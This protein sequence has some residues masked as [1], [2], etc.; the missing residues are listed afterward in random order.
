[1]PPKKDKSAQG[2]TIK[3]PAAD[4]CDDETITTTSLPKKRGRAKWK[5]STIRT[6]AAVDPAAHER[7]D[8]WEQELEH[9]LDNAED[10]PL[11]VNGLG[12]C[13]SPECPSGV[14]AANAVE[15]IRLMEEAAAAEQA[16]AEPYSPHAYWRG[17]VADSRRHDDPARFFDG[18]LLPAIACFCLRTLSVADRNFFDDHKNYMPREFT[19][20]GG[21]SGS[22]MDFFV[23]VAVEYALQTEVPHFRMKQLFFTEIVPN[24]RQWIASVTS[25]DQGSHIFRDVGDLHKKEATCDRHAKS[26]GKK[27]QSCVVEGPSVFRMGFS[28]KDLSRLN[29]RAKQ[30]GIDLGTLLDEGTTTVTLSGFVKFL[31]VFGDVVDL[32]ILENVDTMDDDE[33]HVADVINFFHDSG[34]WGGSFQL[35]SAQYIGAA[36]RLRIYIIGVR[37]RGKHWYIPDP[38]AFFRSIRDLMKAWR[39]EPL[40]LNRVMLPDDHKLVQQDHEE[41]VAR[42]EDGASSFFNDQKWPEKQMDFYAKKVLR[43][44]ALSCLPAATASP[45]FSGIPKRE[46]EVLAA[47]QQVH[48]PSFSGNL[49]QSIDRP[50]YKH[51]PGLPYLHV[52]TI[53]PHAHIWVGDRGGIQDAQPRFINGAEAL[54][55]QGLPVLQCIDDVKNFSFSFL[56]DLAGNAYS[57]Q[58]MTFLTM[59]IMVKLPW[60]SFEERAEAESAKRLLFASLGLTFNSGCDSSS[61]D[62]NA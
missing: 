23:D 34:L 54:M 11:A 58:V 4:A 60:T 16:C 50:P 9:A 47:Y 36:K 41:R 56:H 38:D 52:G 8:G 59:A 29:F 46:R 51:P 37:Q 27:A 12:R 55:I 42:I 10:C 35:N 1:M 7:L 53:L 3:R 49:G 26:R 25:G 61:D 6:D 18:T 48:G 33:K 5:A 21:C 2:V 62:D 24:K 15:N 17:E 44:G 19:A 39:Q 30:R 31:H 14:C 13:E 40:D 20:A 43:W 32:V 28:C 57:G 22:A 45:F